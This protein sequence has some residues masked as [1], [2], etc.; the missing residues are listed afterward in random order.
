MPIEFINLTEASSLSGEH[1]EKIRR[2]VNKIQDSPKDPRRSQV[3]PS[4]E[5]YQL[6]KKKGTSFEWLVGRDLIV[7]EYGINAGE[8]SADET[9]SETGGA[10]ELAL[11]K[12]RKERIDSLEM[13]LGVKDGQI[14]NLNERLRE[15]HI[16]QKDASDQ[17]KQIPASVRNA[18][19]RGKQNFWNKHRYVSNLWKRNRQATAANVV[20]ASVRRDDPTSAG[21]SGAG[22][23]SSS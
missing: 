15:A 6:F 20:D 16:L 3:R 22:N 7:E 21:E 5:D 4:H 1:R 18:V 8:P 2:F 13:Q 14:Q 12:E 17:L 9:Q 11:L 23:S 10:G 19:E